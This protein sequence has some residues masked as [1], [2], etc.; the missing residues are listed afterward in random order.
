[1]KISY[2]WLKNYISTDKTPEEIGR[3]LTDT[4]LEVESIEKLESVKG[5]LEGVIIGQVVSCE[6]H[7]DADKLKL[8]VVDIGSEKLQIVCGASNVG[9]G[10]KVVVATVG[11][12]L[13]PN[14]DEPFKIKAAKIRGVDSFG[15]ICAEDEL[16]LGNS[17]S[18]IMILPN[19]V[20]IGTKA[21]KYF[22]LEDDY[23]FEIG[24]T[25]NRA[26]AMGHI[27]VAR[28]LM[29]YLNFHEQ[30][31]LKIQWPEVKELK[32]STE[33]HKIAIEIEEKTLCSAYCGISL[34]NIK[35]APSPEWLQKKLRAIGLN[36]INNVVDA[37]NFVM[38]EL[39]TP[40]HAFDTAFLNGR[41][42]V[43]K[44]AKGQNFKTLDGIERKLSGEELMISNGKENLCIAGVLG[45]VFSSVS[46]ETTS[47]FL[48]S[49]V[50]DAVSVRKTARAH[51]LNTDASFR[52]ERGVD[53]ELTLYALRRTAGIIKEIAGGEIAMNEFSWTSGA[54]KSKE[55]CIDLSRI[56]SLI[57]FEIPK[58]SHLEILKDLDFTILKDNENLLEI[59]IPGYRI[60]VTREADVTEE[61]LRIF[62]FNQIPIP[63]KWN[64]ALS[65]KA[66]NKTD[67]IQG[68]I[69]ETLVSKGFNE[70]M[71]NSLTK[72]AYIE[73]FGGESFK[74]EHNVTMLNPLSQDLN[75]MR[76]TLLFGVLENM[77]RNQ[78]RQ[79]PNLKF[80]EFGKTY[81]K[82]SAEYKEKQEL[83]LC[84][85][86]EKYNER[87]NSDKVL[88]S[89]FTLKG[90]VTALFDRLGLT[91]HLQ[92]KE[93][94]INLFSQGQ[95]L[96]LF[97]KSIC[98]LGFVKDEIL[99]HF[100]LKNPVFCAVIDW[101]LV[102]QNLQT[103]KT[104]FKELPK[105]FSVRRDFSLL[106]NKNI[107][108]KELEKIAKLSNKNILKSVGLFDVYE[109]DKIEEGKK[110]YA[111][112]FTFQDDEKTLTDEE[113][114]K[115][116][117]TIKDDFEKNLGAVLRS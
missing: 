6:Q 19:D 55:I 104:Q 41:I 4:G 56:N 50:F 42:S 40:I 109:G 113:I 15:M 21:A 69:S 92:E 94:Q 12:T 80:F 84:I 53:P 60:D 72:S 43:K 70:V 10:Q 82:F 32:T 81:F 22:D 95:E 98:Q 64:L 117:S 24:L 51:S 39:G 29:A 74:A 102:L 105:T 25:P 48:E 28:D 114:D 36:P 65:N 5:G 112:S 23:I 83:I 67:K 110:S 101:D 96:D 86:G 7:P 27:G 108:F 34:S 1:M 103:V 37:T 66:Q 90:L 17:H 116:M 87:W 16:G 91:P 63:E 68:A 49:A 33:N 85:T 62:G 13:Y 30:K 59:S 54:Y 38:R 75:V 58:K 61:I 73:K 11:C 76:Q 106:L 46:G 8:T 99:S 100:D 47:V 18:G 2:N 79:N 14:P 35:I 111:L 88:V 71:N 44:A 31:K 9:K 45:G 57:G 97:K 26:D 78:N 93:L 77:Q 3:V 89:Y 52:F 107:Q 115:V 20:A